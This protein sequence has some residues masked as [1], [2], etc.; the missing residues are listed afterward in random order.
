MKHV[1]AASVSTTI[2]A[3]RELVWLALTDRESLKEFFFGA[4]VNSTWAI[5]DPITFSGT[6]DGKSYEDKGVIVESKPGT[7]LSFT[8]WSALSGQPDS[9]ENYHIVTIVLGGGPDT[10]NVLLVQENQDGTE[11][12]DETR[13]QL[14]KNW[15]GVL[16]GL[17]KT[18]ESRL[19]SSPV[20][21]R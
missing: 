5:G 10:T 8:H 7:K 20:P 21:K 2:Q 4:D 3:P 6:Y 13:R 18:V 11:V 16:G 9:P 15:G 14:E 12:G 1:E 19:S 17:R